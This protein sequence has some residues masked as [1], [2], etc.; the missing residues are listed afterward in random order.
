[1]VKSMARS[2]Y[3]WLFVGFAISIAAFATIIVLSIL[4]KDSPKPL[5]PKEYVKF[6]VAFLP[7]ELYS[8]LIFLYVIPIGMVL[9][10]LVIGVPMVRGLVKV[11]GLAHR[12]AKFG[13][14]PLGIFCLFC[15][16]KPIR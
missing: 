13:I 7:G 11:H 2:K 6:F 16:I 1:M 4:Q 5:I 3:M 14:N 10:F 9:L 8:D 15:N 12:R